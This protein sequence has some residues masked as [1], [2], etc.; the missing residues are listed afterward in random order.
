[1]TP[2]APDPAKKPLRALLQHR[3]SRRR[4]ITGPVQLKMLDSI[5]PDRDPRDREFLPAALALLEAPSTPHAKRLVY[6]IC[7]LLTVALLWSWFGHL[8]VYADASGKVQPSGRTKIIQPLVTGKII[9]IAVKDGDVV[10][11]DD[12]LLEL[13]PT[14]A[15]AGQS[16]ASGKLVNAQAEIVRRKAAIEALHGTTVDVEP[17]L[18][19]SEDTPTHVRKR[20]EQA[21]RAA[22]TSLSA[23]L[24]NL[25]AQKNQKVSARD[26]YAKSIAAQQAVVDIIKDQVGMVRTL[27]DKGWDS[28]AQ[29]LAKLLVQREAEL[30]QA[31]LEG[32]L[33]DA[34]A[35]IPVIEAEIQ[36]TR[37]AFLETNTD[38]LVQLYREVEDDREQLIKANALVRQ[39]TLRA[40]MTGTISASTVT[41][42]GQVVSTGQQLM[43]LVP[44]EGGLEIEAYVLNTDIGFVQKGQEATVQVD[45]YPYTRYG[46]IS[47]SVA[48]IARDAI[49]G[50][51]AASQQ[52]NGSQPFPSSGLLAATSAA[53]QTHDLVFPVLIT[54]ERPEIVVDGKAVPLTPGMT[55]SVQIKTESRRAIDYILSPLQAAGY[56]AAHER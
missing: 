2:R 47:G 5:R 22:L 43:Q 6:A 55:V 30:T 36:K 37:E 49:P 21:V 41:T 15:L 50:A 14:D 25:D 34:E 17:K 31:G 11:A 38:R 40:P 7:A 45:A 26:R 48:H 39:M 23:A 46:A 44:T 1:M 54:L 27:N 51:V 29:Y 24:T 32:S 13:D 28:R 4:E 3:R 33:S 18:V 10:K 16:V 19:W 20:E 42:V 56:S 35:A 8:D 12:V 52:K 53:Q 9:R